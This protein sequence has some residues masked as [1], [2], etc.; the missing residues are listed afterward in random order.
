M[1]GDY[2]IVNSKG[3]NKFYSSNYRK[4][5]ITKEKEAKP[6]YSDIKF[7]ARAHTFAS[8]V[9]NY[10]SDALKIKSIFELGAGWGYN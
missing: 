10:V 2:A 3:L 4:E 1:W 5:I 7:L 8:L 9:K 6:D